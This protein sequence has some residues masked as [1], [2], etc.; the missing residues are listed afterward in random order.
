MKKRSVNNGDAVLGCPD[1]C[2]DA[3]T[4]HPYDNVTAEGYSERHHRIVM[5]EGD[6]VFLE[7]VQPEVLKPTGVELVD[8]ICMTIG[9]RSRQMTGAD[10]VRFGE[11]VRAAADVL[12][13]KASQ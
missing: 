7:L 12:S 13:K 6:G 10:L 1:W 9:G 8:D 3:A 4:G 2:E 5:F 11:A